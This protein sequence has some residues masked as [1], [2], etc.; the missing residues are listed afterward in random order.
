LRAVTN[1]QRYVREHLPP[2][3]IP[4]EREMEIVE[5]LALQ[6][7]SAYQAAVARG[8]TEEEAVACAHAEVPDWS[9]LG[10]AF[11]RIERPVGV[12]LPIGLSRPAEQPAP[13]V[14]VTSGGLMSGFIQDLRYA[15]RA[16]THAP[17]F[18]AVAIATLA[19]AIGAT[20]LVYSLVDGILLKPL[21]V[22]DPDRVVV[23]R[24]L[25]TSGEEVSVSWPNYVDWRERSKSF[26]G[27]A[28]WRGMPANLTNVDRPRRIMT[29]Q[30]T[31]NVFAVLGVRPILGRDLTQEDDQPGADLVCLV[32]DGFWQ[33]EMGGDSNA[34]GRQITIDDRPMTVVGVLPPAFTIAREED[35]F[36][37]LGQFRA[38][39]SPMLNRGNHQGL[40][41]LGR[42]APGVAIESAR[43][44]LAT[45]AAQLAQEHPETTRGQGSATVRPLFDVLVSTAR[46]MLTVL[47]G[48]ALAM[49]LIACANLA[50]LLLARSRARAHELAIRRALGAVGWRIARQLLSESVLLGLCGGLAGALLAWVGL[51]TVLSLLSTDQPRI[52]MVALDLRVMGA[53]AAVSVIT[54]I[55]F[56]LVPALNAAGGRAPSLLRQARVTDTSSTGARPR[57]LLLFAEIAIAFTLLAGAGLMVRTMSNLLAIDPGFDAERFLSAQVSLPVTRYAPERRQAFYDAALERIRAI[58]GISSAAFT[59]SLPVQGSNWNS[60]FIVSDQPVPSREVLPSAAFTPVTPIY[61]ATMGIRLLGGRLLSEADGPQSPTVVVINESFARRFW[62]AGDAIGHRIKQGWPEDQT[63]WRE[64]VGVVS[65]V[66]TAGVDQPPAIQ[67]YLPITQVPVPSVA[68]VARTDGNPTSYTQAVESA[69]HAVDPNLPVYDV[70]TMDE[71]IGLGMGQQRLTTVFLLGFAT[72]AM[73]IATVG[74][75]GVTAYAVSQ[76]THELG[77]RMALGANRSNVLTLV[78]REE[79]LACVAGIVVGIAG[80][81]ALSSVLQTLLYGVAPRDPATL[82]VV[83]LLLLMVTALAAY[84]P[85]WRATRIDP[86]RALRVE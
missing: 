64:I 6:L 19:L 58:P 13:G 70:R 27:L 31:W 41:A 5:E 80:A 52:H 29:R 55:L 35:V 68:L 23:A 67:A 1:W 76:R 40:A 60:V 74:V 61:H 82:V 21:A 44:E 79:L 45:I 18:T 10:R 34:I 4:A 84:L 15:V 86:V 30:V 38:P 25:A 49:L 85:A 65:D 11:T 59:L 39:G 17:G 81:L 24:E 75:F 8:S 3:D 71:V 78:L 9:S 42:L 51:G 48:A 32:S 46:Q 54:G 63:P 73:V 57:R 43:A 53:A 28:A 2:L 56:G 50:N 83:S 69:I 16:L 36:R 14:A 62:P 7:E 77:V 47:L 37:P 33:R 12:R 66:K 72:L 26:E 20:T 22:R